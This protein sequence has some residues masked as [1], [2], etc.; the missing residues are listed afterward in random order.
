MKKLARNLLPLASGLLVITI[1]FFGI[2]GTAT[3]DSYKHIAWYTLNHNDCSIDFQIYRSKHRIWVQ[4]GN[5]TSS[6]L[7]RGCKRAGSSITRYYIDSAYNHSQS[8][9]CSTSS[10]PS[11]C[12]SSAYNE[13]V[14]RSRF[15]VRFKALDYEKGTWRTIYKTYRYS[16]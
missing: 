9:Y 14:D 5:E 15:T 13:P 4:A 2:T 8:K 16:R 3:A 10:G 11:T 7:P 1:S 6:S 12:V